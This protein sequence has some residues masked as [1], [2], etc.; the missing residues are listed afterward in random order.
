MR[1]PARIEP[2]MTLVSG[3]V[4]GGSYVVLAKSST[5]WG[6]LKMASAMVLVLDLSLTSA[7]SG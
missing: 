4:G 1:S 5:G 7:Q 2:L 3:E 6:H